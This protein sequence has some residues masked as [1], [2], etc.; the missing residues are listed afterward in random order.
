MALPTASDNPFPS[1]L[2]TEG[3][4]P[5][6]PASGKQRVYIDSTSHQ[7]SR[8]NS[9][10]TVVNLETNQAAAS[11]LLAVGL[12][13]PSAQ[14]IYSITGTSMADVDATNMIVTFTAPA[15]G[16][17]LVRL[18]AFADETSV[19]EF[20]WGLR[21]SSSD[22]SGSITRIIRETGSDRY[23]SM[24][25]YLTGVSAGSH[26]YKWSAAVSTGT[27]RII[28][29]DGSATGKWGPAIMEVWSAP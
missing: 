13:A 10:G 22:I 8:K 17:I 25:I 1:L 3:T 16:K 21:E 24:P 27:S 5:A 11:S 2:V 18:N 28:I 6:S 14:T 12:Y 23:V 15:S 4:A 7:L 9:S 20:Y 19:G 26:T 29:Q